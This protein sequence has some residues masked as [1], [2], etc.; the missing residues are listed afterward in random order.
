MTVFTIPTSNV[1][2][3]VLINHQLIV[4]Y[5]DLFL[6]QHPT[7]LIFV[8]RF[9]VLALDI[10]RASL[11][12]NWRNACVE[13][14]FHDSIER[15]NGIISSIN[16]TNHHHNGSSVFVRFES[17]DSSVESCGR[18]VPDE[19]VCVFFRTSDERSVAC[20]LT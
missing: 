6:P 18:F 9:Q 5:A 2:Y 19:L 14:K 8:V 10:L 16:I 1:R 3:R 20:L 15:R 13:R 17:S 12:E 4:N 11:A 7:I